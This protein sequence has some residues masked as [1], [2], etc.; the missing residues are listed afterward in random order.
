MHQI[1]AEAAHH[2]ADEA[3]V[4]VPAD[5]NVRPH[6]VVWSEPTLSS[7]DPEH[8]HQRQTFMPE[9]DNGRLAPCMRDRVLPPLELPTC[10]VQRE[11][12]VEAKQAG[13]QGLHRRPAQQALQHRCEPPPSICGYDTISLRPRT[14]A[15][16][17]ASACLLDGRQ[18]P[19][20]ARGA[21][22]GP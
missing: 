5:Q 1:E 16:V 15:G 2:I 18:D 22:E 7:D 13:Q 17:I 4:A 8:R 11:V 14:E 20:P 10:R 3:A 6:P 21:H 9:G 19:A 12:K